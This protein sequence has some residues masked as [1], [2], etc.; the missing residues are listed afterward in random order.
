MSEP[1]S[2]EER[3]AALEA[4]QNNDE[5]RERRRMFWQ[6]GGAVI[7]VVTTCFLIWQTTLM[8]RQLAVQADQLRLQADG[9]YQG[10][11]AVLIATLYDRREECS[12]QQRRC[13]FGYD[14]QCTAADMVCPLRADVRT[15]EEALKSLLA[16]DRAH[17][18]P[19]ALDRIDLSNM[20]LFGVD[21]RGV[22]LNSA[23]FTASFLD[24]ARFE[25]ADVTLSI[26]RGASLCTSFKQAHADYIKLEGAI[27]C[28]A[29]WEG[30]KV[31]HQL[32]CPDGSDSVGTCT[33]AARDGKAARDRLMV[34]WN[35]VYDLA[36]PAPSAP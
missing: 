17:R 30:F 22:N 7:A 8:G 2:L 21:F 4:R 23:D 34:K 14:I 10:R 35:R 28:P 33:G 24:G 20:Q 13:H 25:E 29:F 36:A 12:Q 18:Q 32:Q 16:L 5:R 6:A 11:R 19:I 31:E 3:L 27:V 1:S 9:D 26:F 15:R